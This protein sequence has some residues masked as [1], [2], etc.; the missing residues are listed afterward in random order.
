MVYGQ[1]IGS[2]I[3]DSSRIRE[4]PEVGQEIDESFFHRLRQWIDGAIL[5]NL[6]RLKGLRSSRGT[7]LVFWCH[8]QHGDV[9]SFW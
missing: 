5:G 9:P 2:V 7:S 3:V 4:V 1:A 8:F 6:I